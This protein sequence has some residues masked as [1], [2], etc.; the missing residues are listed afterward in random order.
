MIQQIIPFF[1]LTRKQK[2]LL[3]K[4]TLMVYL[5]QSILQLKKYQNTKTYWERFGKVIDS[6][7]FYLHY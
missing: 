7:A 5:N 1:V 3:I 2:Q 6:T 4:A